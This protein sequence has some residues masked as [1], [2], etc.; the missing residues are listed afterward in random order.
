V[1]SDIRIRPAEPAD[2]AT[3][4]AIFVRSWQEAY[5]GMISQEYLDSM[6]PAEFQ[7]AWGRQLAD[8]SWP[9]NVTLVVDVDERV[10][11]FVG[12]RPTRDED[13]D[14]RT[15]TGFTSLYLESRVRGAGIGVRLL[16]S[17]LDLAETSYKQA[18]GWVFH[19][20]H[21]ARRF[22]EALGWYHDGTVREDEARGFTALRY[23]YVWRE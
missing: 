20:Y 18:T 19:N 2:A 6:S 1:S 8:M 23:R 5:R 7:S 17:A 16:H 11:G 10:A 3:I 22:Y 4:A 9:R 12:F 13:D 21:T 14:P 15:V